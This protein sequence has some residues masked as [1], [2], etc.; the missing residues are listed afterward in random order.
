[1]SRLHLPQLGTGC[2]LATRREAFL[3]PL[4][5]DSYGFEQIIPGKFLADR[6]W[7]DSLYYGD[8]GAGGNIFRG[9]SWGNRMVSERGVASWKRI[10][11]VT[12]DSGGAALGGCN[13]YLYRT[14]DKTYLMMVVSASDGVYEVG[15]YDATTECFIVAYKDGT[16]VMGTTINTLVGS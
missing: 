15:I 3:P 10:A 14:S 11:G 2:V 7:F 8:V 13:V 16:P 9:A 4:L 12:K 6:E 5:S 1:M